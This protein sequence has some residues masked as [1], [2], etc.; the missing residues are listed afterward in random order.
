MNKDEII[1]WLEGI[2]TP[3]VFTEELKQDIIDVIS[4]IQY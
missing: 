4:N 1:E 3:Q 2:D